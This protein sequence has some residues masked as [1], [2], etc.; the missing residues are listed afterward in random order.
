MK[1]YNENLWIEGQ[2]VF[3]Y[4]THV[5]TI[6]GDTLKVH[7]YWSRTTSKHINCVAKELGLKK[8]DAPRD[9]DPDEGHALKAVAMVAQLGDIL[10]NSLT[11]K[12]DWKLRM[13]KAGIPAIDFPTDWARLSED[14]KQRRLD[15][16]I[17]AIK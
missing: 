10:C 8:V 5:A 11:A 9:V 6:E 12:N 14:E 2:E 15:G 3:S 17:N 13:L 7:G 1:R 16:A 4:D